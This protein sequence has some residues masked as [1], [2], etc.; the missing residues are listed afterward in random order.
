[1]IKNTAESTR[2][3]QVFRA[4]YA[5]NG[6][7][8]NEARRGKPVLRISAQTVRNWEARGMIPKPNHPGKHRLYSAEQ[9]LLLLWLIRLPLETEDEHVEF[10]HFRTLVF[11]RWNE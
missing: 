7:K 2:Q 8:F 9:V 5:R 10:E 1:M 6:A 11:Q 4:W 3:N